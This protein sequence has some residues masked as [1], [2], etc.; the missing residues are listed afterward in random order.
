[1]EVIEDVATGTDTAARPALPPGM[2]PPASAGPGLRRPLLWLGDAGAANPEYLE[3]VY[4]QVAEMVRNVVHR[5][6]GFGLRTFVGW[7]TL[8][9]S[10]APETVTAA[11]PGGMI[12]APRLAALCVSA[13]WT[14]RKSNRSPEVWSVVTPLEVRD[15]LLAAGRSI[16]RSLLLGEG[17]VSDF[18]PVPFGEAPEASVGW[19]RATL[20]AVRILCDVHVHNLEFPVVMP[21][22]YCRAT[23]TQADGTT[24]TGW[25]PRNTYL[26]RSSGIV[27]DDAPEIDLRFPVLARDRLLYE[28]VEVWRTSPGVWADVPGV[29]PWG[30]LDVPMADNDGRALPIHLGNEDVKISIV[31]G[32]E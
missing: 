8:D 16:G 10:R 31:P 28:D 5:K 25:G 17:R 27:A 9:P 32:R 26:L 3:T 21:D 29:A 11:V 12:P 13:A 18:A 22:F 1:M 19:L 7:V 14:G 2:A 20:T 15:G 24:V 4:P 6:S 23:F 30:V